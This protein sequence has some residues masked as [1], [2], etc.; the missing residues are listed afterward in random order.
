M[1]PCA[2]GNPVRAASP[3]FVA[4]LIKLDVVVRARRQ[5]MDR[6]ANITRNIR[7]E[8]QVSTTL[9]GHPKR[10]DALPKQYTICPRP[11]RKFRVH[12]ASFVRCRENS[13]FMVTSFL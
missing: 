3:Y 9:P 2:K 6:T 7:D 10:P 8:V 5:V 4:G 13:G 12:V 11:S 1:G